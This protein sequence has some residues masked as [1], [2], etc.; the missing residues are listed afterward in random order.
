MEVKRLP[1]V[2]TKCVAILF[3]F[4]PIMEFRDVSKAS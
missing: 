3:K 4:R 1:A 2:C